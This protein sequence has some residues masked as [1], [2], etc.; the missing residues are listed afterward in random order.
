MYIAHLY[1]LAEHA[2]FYSNMVV[3]ASESEDHRSHPGHGRINFSLCVTFGA[4]R[5]FQGLS[6]KAIWA[7]YS[8]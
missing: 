3:L 8:P 7:K 5:D 2:A 6:L 4:Q 1:C